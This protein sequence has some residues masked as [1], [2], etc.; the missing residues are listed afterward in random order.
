M[1]RGRLGP[2]WGAPRGGR[3]QRD[4]RLFPCGEQHSSGKIG[5]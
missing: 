4:F 2:R 5:V 3:R 1:K